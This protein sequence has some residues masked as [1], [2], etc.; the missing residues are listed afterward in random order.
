MND[1]EIKHILEISN[2]QLNYCKLCSNDKCVMCKSIY[3]IIESIPK[4]IDHINILDEQ[5]DKLIDESGD[6]IFA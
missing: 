1:N 4:L 5:I 3:E 2:E 6:D